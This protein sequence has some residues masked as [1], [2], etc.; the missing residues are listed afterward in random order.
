MYLSARAQVQA[1]GAPAHHS[2]SRVAQTEP[3][4]RPGSKRPSRLLAPSQ[5]KPIS[6]SPAP[7]TRSGRWAI[8]TASQPHTIPGNST[9]QGSILPRVTWPVSGEAGSHAPC[10]RH[11]LLLSWLGGLASGVGISDGNSRLLLR[12]AIRSPEGWGQSCPGPGLSL[13]ICLRKYWTSW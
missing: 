9:G 3:I 12:G 13:H 5:V 11:V 4:L 1:L 2:S 7:A 10:P 6:S 8:P